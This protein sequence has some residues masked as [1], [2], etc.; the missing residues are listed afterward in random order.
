MSAPASRPT[1][2]DLLR[3]AAAL[4]ALGAVPLPLPGA[5]PDDLLVRPHRLLAEGLRF[6]EGPVALADGSV[7]LVEIARRSL[8]RIDPDGGVDV[9]APLRGGPNGAAIGP[10]GACYICNNGGDDFAELEGVLLPTG[11]AADYDG[12][13]IE[14]VDLQTGRA[15]TLYRQVDG[16]P[17]SAPN[18]LIFDD[19]GGFWFT[20]LGKS[21]DRAR[22]F[23]GIHYARADG[24]AI[25]QVVY[26]VHA[27]NGIGLSPDGKTLF[28]AELFTGRLIAF[29]VTG[30]GKLAGT[31]GILPGRFVAAGPGRCLFDSIAVEADGTICVAAPIPGEVIC[32]APD[33]RMV[34]RVTMPGPLPTNLCFGGPERRTAYIT[35]SGKGQLIAMDWPRA[36]LP[37]SYSAL[38]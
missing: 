16:R 13:W 14:R 1:R 31:G 30:A 22:D 10:D 24:S 7:L 18:D 11:R 20:D 28:V 2:R 5:G 4:A 15:E 33:G 38:L 17:L 19:S 35:L 6:P 26:P 12:G 9:I 23:G 3:S 32:Y 37:L 27:P 8:T 29:E 34:E 25:T 21:G 36:G